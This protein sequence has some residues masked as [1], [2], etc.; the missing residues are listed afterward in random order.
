MKF[1]HA[2]VLSLVVPVGSLALTAC[3]GG[4]G[5]SS[6]PAPA[7]APAPPP[8]VKNASPGGIWKG[9]TSGG[10]VLVGLVTEFGE[11]TFLQD[12]GVQYFC[13][14]TV[15]GNV[16]SAGFTGVTQVGTA[17]PNGSTSGTGSLT[18]TIAERSTLAGSINFTTAGGTPAGLQKV[19]VSGSEAPGPGPCRS[20]ARSAPAN[21]SGPR[22]AAPAAKLLNQPASTSDQAPKPVS[23]TF[24]LTYDALYDR[25]SSLATIAGNFRAPNGT[26]VSVDA[27]G[28]IFSQDATTGCVVNGKASIIDTR[29]NAYYF[30]Y[31][32]GSCAGQLTVLNGVTFTGLGTLDNTAAPE[33]AIIAVTYQTDT[34]TLGLIEVLDRI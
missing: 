11:F 2:T 32:F 34:T 7:A 4:G 9:T 5:G 20:S 18:A 33:Q 29:Y 22:P 16:V 6:S 26:V 31:K 21:K 23:G 24:T 28:N 15:S 19:L 1:L 3:G 13:N 10:Q 27:S 12:D 30:E 8:V 14:M 25:D 17:F